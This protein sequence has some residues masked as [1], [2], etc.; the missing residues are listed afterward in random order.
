MTM[1]RIGV[2][3]DERDAERPLGVGVGPPHDQHRGA[4]D[5]ER[6]QRADVDQ[7]GQDAERQEAR[8][9]GR[10]RRRSGSSTSRGCGTS[11]WIAPK[12]LGGTRPSRAIARKTRGWLS[13]ITSRT[14]VI[15]VR[16]PSE[17]RQL[18]PRAG[19]S[20]RRRRRPGRRC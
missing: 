6:Q 3:G 19:P 5:H 15:P 10:R 8:P 12:K 16:A 1:P 18:A 2:S 11:A 13:I 4:D 9:S 14:E 20:A 7:L 17:I